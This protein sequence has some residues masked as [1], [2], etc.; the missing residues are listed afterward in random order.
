MFY[1]RFRE[2]V[3]LDTPSFMYKV[4][5]ICL[6]LTTLFFA[7]AAQAQYW[8][9]ADMTISDADALGGN[10]L[11][12][13]VRVNG[14]AVVDL[15]STPDGN[16]N[17]SGRRQVVNRAYT[18][19]FPSQVQ[20]FDNVSPFSLTTNPDDVSQPCYAGN[21]GFGG[22]TTT[23]IPTNGNAFYG[24]YNGDGS[25]GT[26]F[27]CD[28]LIASG[29]TQY[30]QIWRLKNLIQPSNNTKC[31]DEDIL[32]SPGNAG[33]SIVGVLY[34]T[35]TVS[36]FSTLES[37]SNPVGSY[38][39]DLNTLPNL[40]TPG[41]ARFR[42]NYGNGVLS[43]VVTY[44]ITGCSPEITDVA[45][46]HPACSYDQGTFTVTF[47][48][49]LNGDT[50]TNIGL[51]SPGPNGNFESPSD[52]SSDDVFTGALP[53]TASVSGTTFTYPESVSAGT[54]IFSYQTNNNNTSEQSEQF[55]I[56]S[57]QPLTYSIVATSD[58][59]CFDTNDGEITIMIDATNTG[60]T[61]ANP[62]YYYTIDGG[63]LVTFNALSTTITGLGPGQIDIKVFDFKDCT[64]R[65]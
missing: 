30:V 56:V 53:N 9:R 49:S 47:E 25:G 6:Y 15:F 52:L 2:S 1:I 27:G 36:T 50:L 8:V 22:S 32:L 4:I 26:Y 23:N 63:S 61:G 55:T 57:P 11:D 37:F 38:T 62:N 7:C 41:T 12:A 59:S 17:S 43:N 10:E 14:T 20:F 60:N 16:N 13:E 40:T 64:E 19:A 34:S 24:P 18:G 51:I 31:I 58:I 39:V 33:A 28:E 5:R 42:L 21:M 65:L 29:P 44:S 54:H 35:N 48:E 3:Y 46:T 45:V